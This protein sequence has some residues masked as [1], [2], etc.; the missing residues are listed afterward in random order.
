MKTE[1]CED[2]YCKQSSDP[3][4]VQC[5][6]P[7]DSSSVQKVLTDITNISNEEKQ[8]SVSKIDK[9]KSP[10]SRKDIITNISNFEETPKSRKRK[11]S[12]TQ[13]EDEKY[14][15]DVQTL[16][17]CCR[18]KKIIRIRRRAPKNDKN[19]QGEPSEPQ[20]GQCLSS[21]RRIQVRYPK[22]LSP[23]PNV[24]TILKYVF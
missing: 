6:A 18:E 12:N 4:K 20:N 11:A 22:T 7:Q 9:V 14:E 16:T 1:D 5:L 23:R 17:K 2:K 15:D 8:E 13:K 10:E 19:T 21:S 3:S 24:K